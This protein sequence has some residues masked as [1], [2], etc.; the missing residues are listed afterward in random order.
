VTTGATRVKGLCTLSPLFL[1]SDRKN[2]LIY[3]SSRKPRE[4]AES[5][6]RPGKSARRLLPQTSSRAAKYRAA[7]INNLLLDAARSVG[8]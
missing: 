4:S 1:D 6:E 2:V 7:S 3:L 5:G 8:V